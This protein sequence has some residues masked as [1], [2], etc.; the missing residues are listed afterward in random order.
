MWLGWLMIAALLWSA[1]P[2]LIIG[3]IKKGY[4]A[5]LHDKVLRADAE[6]NRADWRRSS[7]SSGSASACGGWTPSPRS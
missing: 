6:M 4:A 3:Q 2:V 5:K 7:A 1:I